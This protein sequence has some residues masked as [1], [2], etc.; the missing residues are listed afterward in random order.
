MTSTVVGIMFVL[1]MGFSLSGVASLSIFTGPIVGLAIVFLMI[2]TRTSKLL[3]L[4]QG[5]LVLLCGYNPL[6]VYF[7][8]GTILGAKVLLKVSRTINSES[9]VEGLE[10]G[11]IGSTI[12]QINAQWSIHWLWTSAILLG[13]LFSV[14]ILGIRVITGFGQLLLICSLVVSP[15]MWFLFIVQLEKS[16][17]PKFILGGAISCVLFAISL[18]LL[19]KGSMLGMLIPFV[20]L[21][22]GVSS[23]IKKRTKFES[24]QISTTI[25]ETMPKSHVIW[26][27]FAS[28]VFRTLFIFFGGSLL[29]HIIN[30]EE[31]ATLN[32]EDKFINHCHS[33]AIGDALQPIMLWGYLLSR[34][35]MDSFSQLGLSYIL[36]LEE[37]VIL[38]LLIIGM[39][40]IFYLM[41]RDL[42]TW[43]INEPTLDIHF[44]LMGKVYSLEQLLV[45]GV[46]LTIGTIIL[47]NMFPVLIMIGLTTI[48]TWIVEK[49]ELPSLSQGM[50]TTFVPIGLYFV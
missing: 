28:G 9:Q 50:S 24:N 34:G 38:V 21:S 42:L 44:T 26:S 23:S 25:W 41:R 12:D 6:F 5:A 7:T 31:K 35:E 36:S 46:T 39:Q 1:L 48:Y 29:V 8:L 3:P 47:G 30:K 17:R 32:E 22:N 15:F 33:E 45:L 40:T 49:L 16:E 20:L 10:E 2:V 11:V 19:F 27:V 13:G 43:M 18:V 37:T 14:F 4:I